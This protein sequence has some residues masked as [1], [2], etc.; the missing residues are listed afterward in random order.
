MGPRLLGVGRWPRPRC[1]DRRPSARAVADRKACPCHTPRRT[2]VHGSCVILNLKIPGIKK[3]LSPIGLKDVPSFFI[4][5]G[6]SCLSRAAPAS[7]PLVSSYGVRPPGRSSG[8]RIILL[9]APSHP[10]SAKQWHRAEFVPGHSGGTA[11]VIPSSLLNPDGYLGCKSISR[12]G[13]GCQSYLQNGC[14]GG[15]RPAPFNLTGYWLL[16]G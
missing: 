6:R 7:A 16:L 8:S 12:G 15:F 11:T 13:G 3:S 9:S 1:R 2:A 14:T 5:K 4:L 10:A